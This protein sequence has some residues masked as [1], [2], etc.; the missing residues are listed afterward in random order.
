MKCAGI[1]EPCTA[2]RIGTQRLS[3]T[4]AADTQE[5]SA[6]AGSDPNGPL[7]ADKIGRQEPSIEDGMAARDASGAGAGDRPGTSG[8]ALGE[9][10]RAYGGGEAEDSFHEDGLRTGNLLEE[11]ATENREEPAGEGTDAD[12][13]RLQRD[14]TSGFIFRTVLGAAAGIAVLSWYKRRSRRKP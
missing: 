5:P 8:S 1:P 11:N 7:A 3:T 13:G 12:S 6:A 10:G 4:A 14:N 2:D 9:D